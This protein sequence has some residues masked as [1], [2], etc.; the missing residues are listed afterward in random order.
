MQYFAVVDSSTRTVLSRVQLEEGRSPQTDPNVEYVE[1]TS[2]EFDSLQVVRHPQGGGHCWAMVGND[3]SWV[4]DTRNV[5]TV[6]M[7]STVISE[8]QWVSVTYD[9]TLPDGTPIPG[10]VQGVTQVVR[11]HSPT[12]VLRASIT[13]GSRTFSYAFPESGNYELRVPGL[14]MK[15]DYKFTVVEDIV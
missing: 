15:G 6:T 11:E 4:D 14:L 3:L 9:L 8:N 7:S 12:R 13:D 10:T 2:E 5:L 1:I